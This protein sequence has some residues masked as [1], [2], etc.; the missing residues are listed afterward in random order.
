MC[1]LWEYT[2]HIRVIFREM[3]SLAHRRNGT[4]FLVVGNREKMCKMWICLFW[5]KLIWYQA[6]MGWVCF[7]NWEAKYLGSPFHRPPHPHPPHQCFP[8]FAMKPV[9]AFV[10]Y[11]WNSEWESKSCK[12]SRGLGSILSYIELFL[13][14]NGGD[15]FTHALHLFTNWKEHPYY[16]SQ[17]FT[18]QLQGNENSQNDVCCLQI[19]MNICRIS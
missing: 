19:F 18:C 17:F 7:I 6:I 15:M 8:L 4:F 10:H 5:M 11:T 2:F 16:C 13:A 9:D 14:C 1:V 12:P 3:S